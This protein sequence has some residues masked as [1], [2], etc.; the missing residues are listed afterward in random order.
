MR[1]ERWMYTLP[2]RWRSLIRRNRVEQDLDD[3]IRYHIE[4]QVEDQVASG[5][6]REEAWRRVRRNF[7][8]LDRAK[9]Q[10]R[11]A[12]H[13]ALVDTLTQDVRYALRTLRRNPGFATVAILTLALGIGANTAVFSLVDGILLAPLPYAAPDRLVSITGTYPTGAFASMREESAM[14]EVAAYAEGH[15]FTLKG[16]GEPTRLAGSRVSAELVALLGVKPSLGRWLRAGEDVAPRDHFV[17]LSHALWVSRFKAD[18]RIVG[19]SIDLDGVMREVVAVMPPS[20]QFPSSRTQVW[21]PLGID[22]RNTVRHWAGDFMPV[23][24]RL[25][26][27]ATMAQAHAEVRLFQARILPR[28]PW[29]M[30]ANWNQDVTVVPLQEAM[31]GS[32]RSRLL[33]LTAAVALVLVIACANVG[34]LSLSRAV[35]REREIA[36]R[37]AIGAA[38]RRIA[39][40]LLTES[41]ILASLAAVVGLLL[42]TQ[43]LAVLKLVLPSD[44]P[45]LNEVYLNWR[46]LGFTGA[47]ALLTG[48]VFGLAPMLQASRLRLR[49]PLES[50]GRQGGR[51]VA[52]PFRVALATGQI[53]CAVL[54]VIAAGLLLR[55]LWALSTADPG[56]SAEQILTAR[57]SPTESLCDTPERCVAFY[58]TLEAEVRSTAAIHDAALVNTLPLTGAV[59]KRSLELEGYMVPASETA[60]LFWLT[61]ITPDYFRVMEIGLE[62]G[63]A[64]TR[65]DLAGYSPAAI[66]TSS[67]AR[68]FWPDQNPVGKHVRFVG[69]REWRTIVGV[70]SDV[71]GYDLTRSAPDWIAGVL[72]V[73]HGASATMEDGRLPS[74]MT[75]VM[76]TRMES[77]PVGRLL[78]RAAGA[79]GDVVIGDVRGMRAILTDAVGSPSA[80]TSLLVTMAALAVALACIGVYGVLSFLVSIQMHDFGIRLALGAQRRD[81]FWLVI[82]EGARLCLAGIALGLVGAMASTRWLS[83]EL[84]GVSPTDPVIYAAVAIMIFVVT[85]MACYVPTRRAMGVDPLIVLRDQ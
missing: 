76:R 70:V 32:V 19:R 63:R 53:G 58:R 56:F 4:R 12:R 36:I 35:A 5:V 79:S 81:L 29:K 6:D 21:V 22:P 67:T 66:V 68:R 65:E 27:G 10:C 30:P 13:M 43:A 54:L 11:D 77:G 15:W 74:D 60:P 55:S 8:A 38:P 16:D 42:A 46:V 82:K 85:L 7:G 49:S 14:L 44:T 69:E 20:F 24:G 72:Y 52:G 31:V 48:L 23:I 37:T 75:L 3:E 59:A 57:I 25:R 18:E 71:R 1:F 47:L 40:Q 80:T 51:V 83:S 64:F 62:S 28:F 34:N 26:A 45:R 73:P 41:V 50:A 2:L 17:I 9:E 78:R 84:H 61:V 33:I 39:R